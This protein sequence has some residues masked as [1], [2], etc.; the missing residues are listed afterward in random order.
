MDTLSKD[1]L[2]EGQMDTEYK[3]YV[4]LAY[5]QKVSRDFEVQRIYPRLAELVEHYRGLLTIK[6]GTRSMEGSFPKSMTGFQS[7]GALRFES[8]VK[9]EQSLDEIIAFIDWALPIMDAHLRA[10]KEVYDAIERGLHISAVGLL[11]VNPDHGYM[12][13]CNGN[14][15]ETRVYEFALTIFEQADGRYRGLQTTYLDNYRRN[16]SNTPERIKLDLMLR[17]RE[18]PNPATL[19]IESEEVLPL[20]QALLPVAKRVLVR[21]LHTAV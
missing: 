9:R 6:E 13:I 2:F 8:S 5:L 16:L 1:W 19:S 7:D 3:T 20:D 12:L 21:Y 14:E 17:R 15:P 18:M 11:P 4:L 10:G